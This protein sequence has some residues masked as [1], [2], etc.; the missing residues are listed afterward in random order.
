MKEL[1]KLEDVLMKL[2][3]QK[4][5]SYYFYDFGNCELKAIPSTTKFLAECITF[6]GLIS[7]GSSSQLIDFDLPIMVD[8]YEQG[9]ALI[10]FNL[11]GVK[12]KNKPIWLDAYI[13]YNNYL[14]WNITK[15]K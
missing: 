2:G 8:S 1:I 14:P 3:F 7:A 11:Q 13:R 10:A 4:Q 6:L 9:E 12:F 5:E 15:L